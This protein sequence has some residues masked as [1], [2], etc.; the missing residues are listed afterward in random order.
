MDALKGKSAVVIGASSGVGRATL[1]ALAAQG[2]RVCG[3][4]R[5]RDRLER[6]AREAPGEVIAMAGDATSAELA[7]RVVREM[8]PDLVV[9]AVG[10]RPL[11]G[12]IDQLT[13]E[14]FSAAWNVDLQATFH[15]ARQ[16]IGRPLRPGSLVVILSSGAS[17]GGS[18]LSGGYAGAKRMQ[19][20]LA[21]YL[22]GLSD[23]RK[24][25]IRF[26]ALLPKQLIAGTEIGDAASAAYA[27]QAGISQARFMERFGAPLQPEGVADAIV[28]I[29]RGQAAVEGT[30]FGITGAGGLE[31]L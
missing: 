14:S 20:L 26:V 13:W 31:R 8:D 2:M 10:E 11:M 5:R 19:W 9:V 18:P 6:I 15:V 30:A 21:G 28:Q 23:A 12:P 22:Q 4:A 29:A 7:E 1:L 17:I 27:E 16:A 3:V 25:G 24:L